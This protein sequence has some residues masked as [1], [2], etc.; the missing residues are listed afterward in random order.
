HGRYLLIDND[1]TD[2][3]AMQFYGTSVECIV[4]GNRGT[5]MQ[6]FRGLGLWYHGFQPSWF[7]QFLDNRIL[8][9]NYYHFTSAADSLIDILGAKRGEY[10]G[11]LNLGTVV[12]RN[13]LDSNSHIKVS[14]TCRDVLVERNLV[15][16]SETGLFISQKCSGVLQ[17][18]NRF[19]NV[20]REVV[21]EE[22]MRKAAE[23]RLKQF[24][25]RQEP[26]AAWDFDTMTAGRF[27]DSSGN[28][29]HAGLNGGVKAVAGGI[30]GQAANFDGTGYLKVDEP[31]VFNAPDVSISLWVKPATLRGRRGIIAKRYA[32]SAA[33]FVLSH[34]GA[35]VGFEATD[36]DNKWSFNFVSKPALKEGQWAHVAAVLQ[37][38]VGV[39]LYV[40]GQPIAEKKNPAPRATNDQPLILGREAWG[41]DPP[42]GDTPGFFIGLLDEVKVWARALTPAEVQGEFE[43]G[44]QPK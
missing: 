1:F 23:E 32:G 17:R 29:F 21:D 13:Q 31:A 16:N 19:Q 39:T 30:R 12:R 11:P 9:G 36:E 6:G 22:A 37:Q 28:G 20:K 42:K 2:T 3:G 40:N 27:S 8:E 15:Q 34:S 26:V 25:G 24:L 7:C 18:E 33:P 38:G 4:A 44:A 14:G 35:A 10:A 43:K 5:R 41:G